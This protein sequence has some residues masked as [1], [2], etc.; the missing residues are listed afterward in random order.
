MTRYFVKPEQIS[1]NNISFSP[2]DAHHMFIVLKMRPGSF[3]TALDGTGRALYVQIDDLGRSHATGRILRVDFPRT[4]ANVRITVAQALPRTLDK[5]EWVLEHGTEL[6]ASEFIVFSC[7]RA[8]EN[9]DRFLRKL[10]RWREI[11]KTAA[12]QSERVHLPEVNGILPFS[13]VLATAA[14]HEL[15]LLAY[16]REKSCT[17]REALPSNARDVLI[18]IGPE[19]GFTDEEVAG[20]RSA[21]LLAVSL[22][23]RILRT[24]TAALVMSS[25]ILYALESS[26]DAARA[27]DRPSVGAAN[28]IAA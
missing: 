14:Q 23:P 25:Q 12:E 18:V 2:D 19:G 20:A 17:L 22:G 28:S 3:C 27:S 10:D 16:E 21:G 1:G 7:E 6:G 4:E 15:A 11:V 8:R 5:L 13:E 24:E 9:A 26:D